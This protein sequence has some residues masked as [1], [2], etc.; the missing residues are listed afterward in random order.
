VTLQAYI[1]ES[2]DG[3]GTYILGGCI[4]NADTWK[5]LS[6]DWAQLVERY[7][8]ID[9]NGQRLCHMT[10]FAPDAEEVMFFWR[11]IERH[12]PGVISCQIDAA[13]LKRAISRIAIPGVQVDWD[14]FANPYFVAFRC[15]MD[16]FHLTRDKMTAVLPI[17]EA[18]DFNFDD[19]ADKVHIEKA[20]E[21]Y[22]ENRPQELKAL[23]GRKPEFGDDRKEEFLP[24]QAADFWAWWVRRWYNEGR[25]E[26]AEQPDFGKF[27]AEKLAGKYFIN[28]AFEENDFI[29]ALLNAV[30]PLVDIKIPLVVLPSSDGTPWKPEKRP[31]DGV[32]VLASRAPKQ[33]ERREVSGPFELGRQGSFAVS[34]FANQSAGTRNK[35]RD[36]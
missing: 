23:Y 31:N 21:S 16:K 18:I 19:N 6:A 25:P 35:T 29:P 34:D 32:R 20:W 8:R 7:G 5:A 22:L 28:I 30:R 33:N 27:K 13:E 17:D 26:V 1:D 10:E 14:A 9:G 24:L 3:G 2:Y 12:I 4:A 11:T 15:L 36:V